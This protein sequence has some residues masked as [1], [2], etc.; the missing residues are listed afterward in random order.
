[1][2]GQVHDAVAQGICNVVSEDLAY[3]APGQPA[4]TTSMD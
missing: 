4:A 3:E 2:E 1:M